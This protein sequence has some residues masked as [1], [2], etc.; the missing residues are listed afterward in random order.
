MSFRKNLI[1]F[2]FAAVAASAALAACSHSGRTPS[3]PLERAEAAYAEG[4]YVKA[5]AL[6]DSIV[7]GDAFSA[8]NADGLCRLSILFVRLGENSGQEDANTAFAVHSLRAAG[9]LDSAYTARFVAGL[10]VDDRSGMIIVTALVEAADNPAI[11]DTSAIPAD[12]IP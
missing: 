12:T 5:Q 1:H 6:A 4:R 3:G 8:L 2:F 10:P 11:P 7:L 9:R